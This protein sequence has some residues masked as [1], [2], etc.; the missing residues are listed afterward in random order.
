VSEPKV[1]GGPWLKVW[2]QGGPVEDW[3]YLSL[4]EPPETIYVTHTREPH[5]WV[6]VLEDWEGAHAY[7]REPSV[8]QFDHER[9]YYPAEA[10]E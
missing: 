5:G 10:P 4:V 1:T 6:R 2:L 8:E 3:H 9:I 7:R